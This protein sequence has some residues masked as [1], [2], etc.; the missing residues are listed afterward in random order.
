[1]RERSRRDEN[2]RSAAPM[3]RVAASVRRIAES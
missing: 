3:T 1:M 2:Q